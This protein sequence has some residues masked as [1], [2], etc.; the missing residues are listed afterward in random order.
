[1]IFIQHSHH[2]YFISDA[3]KVAGEQFQTFYGFKHI[4]MLIYFHYY[5]IFHFPSI[6]NDSL[7]EV[8][9]ACR[10]PPAPLDISI[11]SAQPHI[12]REYTN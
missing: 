3:L 12:S 6:R 11:S 9:V 10:A 7:A 4:M 1:M 8:L 5:F 2:F